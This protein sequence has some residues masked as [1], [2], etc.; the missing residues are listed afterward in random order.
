MPSVECPSG[1]WT[2]M[3]VNHSWGQDGFKTTFKAHKGD[4]PGWDTL[5]PVDI[6]AAEHLS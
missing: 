5:D 2:V 3:E 1:Q 6:E 4:L